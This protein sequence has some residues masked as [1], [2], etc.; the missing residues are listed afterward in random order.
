M[1][2]HR[3]LRLWRDLEHVYD[4]Y[5]L[6]RAGHYL[7]RLNRERVNRSVWSFG[8]RVWGWVMLLFMDW[9]LI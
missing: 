7:M 6:F 1:R 8:E 5:V 3:A 4:S 9:M 2:L